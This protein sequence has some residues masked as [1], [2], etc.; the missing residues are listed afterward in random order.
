MTDADRVKQVIYNFIGN[1]MKFTTHGSITISSEVKGRQLKVLITDTG[2]GIPLDR[3][4]LLFHKFQQASNNILTRDTTR[5]TGLGLYISKLLV[6]KMHGKIRLE[7]SEEGKGSTFSF[8]LPL[9]K[10]S[11]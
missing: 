7:H 9:A 5:G 2:S 4:H 1:A 8:T 11:K 6:E 3:Q 10:S